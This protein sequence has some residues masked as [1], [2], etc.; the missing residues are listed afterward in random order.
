MKNHKP[1][2][3]EARVARLEEDVKEIKALLEAQRPKGWKSIV[4]AFAN[5]PV[6][7]EITRLGAEIREKEREK[8]R[9]ARPKQKS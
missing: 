7:D 4:G 2:K 9:R 6:F 8:A 5:D 1:S 3:L